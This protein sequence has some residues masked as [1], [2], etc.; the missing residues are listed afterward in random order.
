MDRNGG[1]GLAAMTAEA[2]ELVSLRSSKTTPT[3]SHSLAVKSQ[4]LHLF[5]TKETY[6][7]LLS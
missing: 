2:V 5:N 3:E 6:A 1:M 4:S 7:K